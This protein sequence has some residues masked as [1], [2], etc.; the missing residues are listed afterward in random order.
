MPDSP[1]AKTFFALAEEDLRAAELSME[2]APHSAYSLLARSAEKAAKAVLCHE[3]IRPP[4]THSVDVLASLLPIGHKWRP[5][6][7][8][9]ENISIAAVSAGYPTTDG[10][11][12]DLPS[13]S[14]MKISVAAVR[15]LLAGIRQDLGLSLPGPEADSR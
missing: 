13:P 6:I 7:E 14:E 12:F 15:T 11:P 5:P 8:S 2:A 10:T 9:L 1:V 4:K 3:G